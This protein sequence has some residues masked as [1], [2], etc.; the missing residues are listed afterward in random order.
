MLLSAWLTYQKLTGK[1]DSLAGCGKGSSCSN[2]LGSRWSV[3]FGSIPVSL[4]SFFVYLTLALSLSRR[5]PLVR[6]V[7]L[8]I[9]WTLVG[10]AVW[11]IGLQTFKFSGFCKYCMATHTIGILV[12]LGL[13]RIHAARAKRKYMLAAPIGAAAV[14]ILAL[15]QILGPIPATHRVDQ[16]AGSGDGKGIHMKGE[17]RLVEFLG[18][19]K[20]YR[21][22]SL[23][24]LGNPDAKHVLVKYFDYT[25]ESCGK[26]DTYL[27][28]AMSQYP[29]DLAVIVLPS[30]LNRSCNK[31]LPAEV[32]DHAKACEFAKYALAVWR[33]DPEQFTA[34]HHWLFKN[35]TVLPE[36]AE[37][38]A[39]KRVGESAFNKALSD[40]WA[41]Q[42]I[43]QNCDDYKQ[44]IKRTP[45]MPKLLLGGSQ[46]LQG[47]STNEETFIRE[48]EKNLHLAQ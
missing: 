40:Q 16:L 47:A 22:E 19:H 3:I 32:H 42:I 6:M 48:L 13:F 30:P 5:S 36:V 25:C 43:K 2:I 45:V 4:P 10:A 41:N 14:G 7:H 35:N 12:A 31:H 21:V 33:A 15:I 20:S 23:P 46:V 11:F 18:G 38:E 27:E 17:G 39:I 28:S 9:A 26:M 34:Y 44:F 8:I 24:H 1:I 37:A 29:D